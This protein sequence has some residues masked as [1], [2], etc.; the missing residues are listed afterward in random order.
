MIARQ[1]PVR[2]IQIAAA[3]TLLLAAGRAAAQDYPNQ[4]VKIVV[5]FAPGGG[6]DVVARIL[7]PRLSERSVNRSSSRTAPAPAARSAPP[8]VAQSPARRLHAA[9]RHRQHAWHQSE[10]LCRLSLRSAARLRA[11]RAGLIV[12]VLAGGD[13][14]RAGKDRCPEPITLAKPTG[15]A[16]LRFVR[17]PAASTI[18]PPSC[19]TRWLA[20]KPTTYP[21]AARRRR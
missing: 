18:S 7:A 8:T 6:V 20:S 17:Q 4:T 11:G 1:L 12:A 15:R 21:I 2:V 19:S 16:Q 10:R 9:A 14:R 5:P 13:L 3:M